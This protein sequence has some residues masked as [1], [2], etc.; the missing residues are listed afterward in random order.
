VHSDGVA[1]I[2]DLLFATRVKLRPQIGESREI[3][4]VGLGVRGRR[5]PVDLC[6]YPVFATLPVDLSNVGQRSER[7]AD[8]PFARLVAPET[9]ALKDFPAR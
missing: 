8:G 6:S 5:G 7:V 9:Q 4:S 1:G 3:P 2:G